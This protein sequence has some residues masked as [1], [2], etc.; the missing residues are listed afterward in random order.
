MIIFIWIYWSLMARN[1]F[2]KWASMRGYLQFQGGKGN[3][4]HAQHRAL[5]ESKFWES[6]IG[7][8]DNTEHGVI[9]QYD[10]VNPIRGC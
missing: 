6:I 10:N 8:F 3:A 2:Q 4:N 5:L 7:V 9:F 1:A